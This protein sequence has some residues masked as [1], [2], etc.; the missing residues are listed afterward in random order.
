M[1]AVGG[2]VVVEVEDDTED[3]AAL[4]GEGQ[5][6]LAAPLPEAF[7]PFVLCVILYRS[8]TAA[9]RGTYR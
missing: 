5:P 8:S 6:V 7:E 2:G 9:S 1:D 4:G 3:R